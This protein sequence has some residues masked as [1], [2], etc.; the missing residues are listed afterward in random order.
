MKML[1]KDIE[2]LR[3]GIEENIPLNGFK[4]KLKKSEK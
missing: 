4:K 3:R 1:K 2:L